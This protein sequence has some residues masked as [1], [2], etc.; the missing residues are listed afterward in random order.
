VKAQAEA[1]AAARLAQ[2][3]APV[4]IDTSLSRDERKR[5]VAE[6]QKR[7]GT[8][9]EM[10]AVA[11][12]EALEEANTPREVALQR[13]LYRLFREAAWIL[14]GNGFPDGQPL[15]SQ[16]RWHLEIWELFMSAIERRMNGVTD[17]DLGDTEIEEDGGKSSGTGN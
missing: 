7:V 6:L 15:F 9:E 4:K 16:H 12:E 1:E 17:A 3:S 11:V 14:R 13:Q 5:L 8:R 2:E 10:L